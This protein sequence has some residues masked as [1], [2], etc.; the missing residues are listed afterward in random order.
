[1]TRGIRGTY[2]YA[3]D[4]DLRDYLRGFIPSSSGIPVNSALESDSFV[5]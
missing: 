5:I 1:M 4:P 2:V 3:C